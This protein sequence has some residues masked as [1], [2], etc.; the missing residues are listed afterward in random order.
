M[1]P[2]VTLRRCRSIHRMVHPRT[3][4]PDSCIPAPVKVRAGGIALA[5]SGAQVRP[6]ES[7]FYARHHDVHHPFA[8][9]CTQL[10]KSHV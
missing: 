3:T 10:A 6:A 2:V 8:K 9:T 5:R 1:N 4:P 7:V